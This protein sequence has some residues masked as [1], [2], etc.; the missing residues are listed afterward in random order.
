MARA[1]ALLI[2]KIALAAER[3]RRPEKVL[4]VFGPPEL[5]RVGHGDLHPLPAL[6]PHA[7]AI[8]GLEAVGAVRAL[9]R[10]LDADRAFSL[11]VRDDS[12]GALPVVGTAGHSQHGDDREERLEGTHSRQAMSG[13]RARQWS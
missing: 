3:R 7:R 10:V 13:P 5:I 8:H 6:G 1:L 12:A 2:L 4:G 9:L 11:E